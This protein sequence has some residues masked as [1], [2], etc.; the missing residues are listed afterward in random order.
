MHI[1][2]CIERNKLFCFIY[3]KRAFT[4]RNNFHFNSFNNPMAHA[5]TIT[6]SHYLSTICR[7][8]SS[9]TNINNM[10]VNE[11]SEVPP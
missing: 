10:V 9:L 6:L 4:Q 5:F 1:F 2:I 3:R 7:S 8:A 11:I